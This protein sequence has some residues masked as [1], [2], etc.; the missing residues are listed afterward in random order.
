MPGME[1]PFDHAHCPAAPVSFSV[2]AVQ[3]GLLADDE[4]AGVVQPWR[5]AI[6]RVG[7]KLAD[8]GALDLREPV[9][10]LLATGGTERRVLDLMTRRHEAVGREPVCLVAHPGNNSLPAAL[11]VLARLQQT[12]SAGRI[13]LLRSPDDEQGLAR[14]AAG[15]ADLGTW[16]AMRRARIGTVGEPSDWLVASA[17]QPEVVTGRWGPQVL[18]LPLEEL[19]AR[20]PK[21]TGEPA[22]SMAREWAQEATSGDDAPPAG[23]LA[24]AAAVW[25]TL[26]AL[27]AEHR[28]D[29]VAVRCFDLLKAAGVTGCLALAQLADEGI[30]AGCEG[31]LCATLGMLLARLRSGR[32][33]WMANPTDVDEESNTVRLAHCTVPRRLTSAYR[34]RSHFESRRSVAVAGDIA[35]GQVTV[36][37][38]GGEQLDRVWLGEGRATPAAP[39]ADSCRTRLD[40]TLD[41]GS[42]EELLTRPLGNHLVVVPGA[43]LGELEGCLALWGLIGSP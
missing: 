13:F 40:V 3:S 11:E 6:A 16:H 1:R 34:L 32:L 25:A 38:I 15:V 18:R 20:L 21:V 37:R 22:D 23:E 27:V 41:V 7:G 35:P 2:V 10:I 14:L 17:P 31:D 4:L 42:V 5:Q 36:L 29:A 30:V 39:S 19:L 43:R 28:L 33:A 9:M 12:G 8:P 26:R 24:K